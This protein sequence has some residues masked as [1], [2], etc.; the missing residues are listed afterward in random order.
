MLILITKH[1]ISAPKNLKQL[2]RSSKNYTSEKT[3]SKAMII[4]LTYMLTDHLTTPIQYL[5]ELK[6]KER[7]P[8]LSV[9]HHSIIGS[10]HIILVKFPLT[11]ISIEASWKVQRNSCNSL[12]RRNIKIKSPELTLSSIIRIFLTR[13]VICFR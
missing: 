9:L 2:S 3:V 13:R 4:F 1:L 11:K 7:R 6:M 5:Q 10:E 12:C 8:L